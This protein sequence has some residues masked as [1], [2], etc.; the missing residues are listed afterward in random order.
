MKNNL[1]NY[2]FSDMIMMSLKFIKKFIF[3]IDFVKR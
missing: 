1:T 3:D 2:V